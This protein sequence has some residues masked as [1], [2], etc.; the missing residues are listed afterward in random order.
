MRARLTST[1]TPPPTTGFPIPDES[2]PIK[3]TPLSAT[4]AELVLGLG[5]GL[6]L[7][8]HS[9]SHAPS[10]APLLLATLG[11]W[12]LECFFSRYVIIRKAQR[13]IHED[14]W[15]GRSIRQ[16]PKDKRTSPRSEVVPPFTQYPF[17]SRSLVPDGQTSPHMSRLVVLYITCP[18]L[19]P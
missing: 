8:S 6:G 14:L 19:S 11:L 18:S 10:H 7:G 13:R 5:L 12:T 9:S 3:D 1:H 15:P 16:H 2:T 17:P 4:S